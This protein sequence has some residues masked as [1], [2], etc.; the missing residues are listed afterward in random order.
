MNAAYV[1]RMDEENDSR[2]AEFKEDGAPTVWFIAT[3][4][5]ALGIV[6]W[7]AWYFDLKYYAGV[8]MK[9]VT[10]WL[11]AVLGLQ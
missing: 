10:D 11:I 8:W 2:W 1:G 6:L 4:L 9:P 3:E 5:V 7:A